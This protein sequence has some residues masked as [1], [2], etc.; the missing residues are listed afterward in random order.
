VR[1]VRKVFSGESL[2]ERF[3]ARFVVLPREMLC[4][5]GTPWKR[6]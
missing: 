1:G 3:L 6:R 2:F 4:Q 5:G